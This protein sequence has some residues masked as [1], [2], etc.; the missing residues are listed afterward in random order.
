MGEF[1]YQFR[2]FCF[3]ISPILLC[4]L[5]CFALSSSIYGVVVGGCCYFS[6][7]LSILSPSVG[8]ISDSK[9]VMPF[10]MRML[11]HCSSFL[12]SLS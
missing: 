11:Y 4:N 10:L 8:C 6:S 7:R 12:M 5:A 3:L 2:P 9:S 1:T